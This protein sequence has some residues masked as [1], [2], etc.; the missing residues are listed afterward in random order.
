MTMKTS[1]LMSAIVALAVALGASSVVMAQDSSQKS[2]LPAKHR[3]P[4]KPREPAPKAH[5]VW[6]EDDLTTVRKPADIYADKEA[7]RA[8]AAAGAQKQTDDATQTAAAKPTKALPVAPLAHANSVDDAD[9]KIAWEQ[10]DIEGQEEFI[11]RLQ[12]ELSEAPPDRR[13]HLQKLI[14]EHN[15]ILADTRKELAGLQAQKKELEKPA[16]SNV[17]AAVQPPSQ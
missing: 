4:T 6:T 12:Q 16:A 13:E 14:E 2:A 11:D 5:K 10:R 3:K 15:R 8:E 7:T 9:K 17:T 1:V